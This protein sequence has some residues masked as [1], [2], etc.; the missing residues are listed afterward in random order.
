MPPAN[1]SR[2]MKSVVSLWFCHVS[3]NSVVI[4]T[5]K[6][7]PRIAASSHLSRPPVR[8]PLSCLPMRPPLSFLA[9]SSSN[10]HRSSQPLP[11]HQPVVLMQRLFISAEAIWCI[12]RPSHASCGPRRGNSV[13]E[14]ETLG[15]SQLDPRCREMRSNVTCAQRYRIV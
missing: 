7:K 3:S 5:R 8:A 15:E 11:S 1:C 14:K 13:T 2:G 9:P 6:S 10:G 12:S 4:I